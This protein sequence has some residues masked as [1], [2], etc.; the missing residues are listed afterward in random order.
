MGVESLCAHVRDSRVGRFAFRD[1]GT[2]GR[3]GYAFH[4]ARH[5]KPKTLAA[6]LRLLWHDVVLHG[7]LNRGHERCE[8]CGRPTGGWR[9]SN[10]RWQRVMGGP[11]GLLCQPCFAVRESRTT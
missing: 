3:L 7:L 5:G 4:C 10:E 1:G 9:T 6:R 8:D 2:L 11:W